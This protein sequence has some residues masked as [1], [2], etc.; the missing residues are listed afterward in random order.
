MENKLEKCV[1]QL[2]E[3]GEYKGVLILGNVEEDLHIL[4]RG[5]FPLF[6][7]AICVLTEALKSIKESDRVNMANIVIKM[8]LKKVG[9]D[10]SSSQGDEKT[11]SGK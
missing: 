2:M 9:D 8:A 4:G 10:E 6:A 5:A 1:N 7:G 3:S 11:D